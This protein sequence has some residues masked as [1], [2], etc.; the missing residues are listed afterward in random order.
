[1][2]DLIVLDGNEMLSTNQK[3][4]ISEVVKWRLIEYPVNKFINNEVNI[5][6]LSYL[7]CCFT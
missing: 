7:W 1:M 3:V 6:S 5:S 2:N 4:N